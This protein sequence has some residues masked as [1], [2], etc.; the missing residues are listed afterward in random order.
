MSRMINLE[1]FENTPNTALAAPVNRI[2]HEDLDAQV[3]AAYEQGYTAGFEDAVRQEGEARQHITAEL[4]RNLQDLGFTF[5]EARIHVLRGLE[6]LLDAIAEAFLPALAA[7]AVGPV[8]REEIMT[9]AEHAADREVLLLVPVG[10]EDVV[11]TILEGQATLP[12]RIVEEPSLG[13]GQALLRTDKLERA[14][15]LDDLVTKV[16]AAIQ[17]LYTQLQGELAHG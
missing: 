3:S 17:G 12:I 10:Q 5:H 16:R 8:L 1:E 14:V 6:P 13:P 7:E 4:A 2:T 15:D 11:T 9:M